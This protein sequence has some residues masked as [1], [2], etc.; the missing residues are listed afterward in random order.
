MNDRGSEPTGKVP[1]APWMTAPETETVMAALTADGGEARFVGGCVRNALLKRP[2]HDIDIATVETPDRVVALLEAAGIRAIPTGIDH[3]TVTAVVGDRP[4]EIT[5]LRIDVETDGRH[6]QVRF[7]DDWQADAARRDF[8]INTLSCTPTGDI[9]DPFGGIDDLAQGH[10]RFVGLAKERI[11]EDL[12]RVL[13]FFRFHASYGRPPADIDAMSACRAGAPRLGELS[14]DR[15]REELFRIL[16]APNPAD[17]I[18]LMHG[19]KV[20]DTLL[21]EAGNVGRLRLMGWLETTAMKLES[22]QPDAIR[23]LAAL[24]ETGAEGVADVAVRLNLSNPQ[25]RRLS[26]IAAPSFTI[27]VDLDGP[28][29]RRLMQRHG[30][31]VVRDVALLTWAAERA[32]TPRSPAGR[33]EDWQALLSAAEGWTSKALPIDGDDVLALGVVAGPRVGQLLDAVT[34]WWEDGDFTADRDACLGILRERA[35]A[36]P[37]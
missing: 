32:V 35:G 2:A 4:F 12:L 24:L 29:R 26:A 31:E 14:A 37:R 11:E 7:V 19:E 30:A 15:V 5:T 21:P 20:L 36:D 16:V 25:S 17:I 34:E 3:G 8:T 9:Y 33:S 10:V 6:A 23:R 27:G 13:R 22:I 18:V 28:A 1:V